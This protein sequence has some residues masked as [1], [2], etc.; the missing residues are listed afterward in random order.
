M[1]LLF[2]NAFITCTICIFLSS[3]PTGAVD[4]DAIDLQNLAASESLQEHKRVIRYSA[5]S[6][7]FFPETETKIKMVASKSY[8]LFQDRNNAL[9][10]SL[11]DDDYAYLLAR[12]QL[13]FSINIAQLDSCIRIFHTLSD[14]G[15]AKSL[16]Q[17]Y[18]YVGKEQFLKRS[19][20]LGYA[21]AITLLNQVNAEE[22]AWEN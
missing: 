6:M 9:V 11:S 18:R 15:H 12:Y 5:K 8:T 7:D 2:V 10:R 3:S 4:H 14:R 19:A 17:L 20:D 16:Y 1:N 22:V 21:K 13:C